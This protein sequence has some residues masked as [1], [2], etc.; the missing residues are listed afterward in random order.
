MEE[1]ISTITWSSLI[2]SPKFKPI[3]FFLIFILIICIEWIILGFTYYLMSLYKVSDN[4]SIGHFIFHI[5]TI[6]K[7]CILISV[8]INFFCSAK[9]LTL[10]INDY[11]GNALLFV[12][13]LF[14]LQILPVI[15]PILL[16]FTT[17]EAPS[18]SYMR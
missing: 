1:K 8:I 12:L 6:C 15:I 5:N 10:I 11:E 3:R 13:F 2:H 7:Y 17:F 16:I 9:T 4:S 14:L 18:Y